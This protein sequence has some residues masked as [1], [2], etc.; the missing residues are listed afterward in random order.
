MAA[1]GPLHRPHARGNGKKISTKPLKRRD[2]IRRRASAAANWERGR[3]QQEIP[4]PPVRRRICERLKIAVIEEMNAEVKECEIV[5]STAKVRG[6][7]VLRMIAAED[8]DV[9]LL[10]PRDN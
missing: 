2:G 1:A 3:R 9:A 5:N 4:A 10:E 7:D 6:G 8:G